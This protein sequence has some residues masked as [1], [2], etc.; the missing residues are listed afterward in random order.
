MKAAGL[1]TR[2]DAAGNTF[3]MLPGEG[4]AVLTGSHIDT[5]PEGG[6]L[7][8]ALGVLAGLEC[9]QTSRRRVCPCG[10]RSRWWR[11][12]TRRGATAA[13]SARG[14]SPAGSTS[15]RSPPCARSTGNRWW[16][17]WRA[18]A[19]TRAGSR[20]PAAIRARC[21]PTWSCTSSRA[22]T[23]SGAHP[24]RPRGGHRGHPPEPPH[25]H[26][27]AGPR[28]HHPDGATQGR[29]P[30]RLRVRAARRA[31]TSSGRAAAGA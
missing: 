25:L 11:G 7:D 24:H 2:V 23:S 12:A 6:P 20:R 17:R 30:G 29:L 31:S 16:R 14:R 4:A 19:T 5:V 15:P 28:R 10:G 22:R 21:T 9:L 18:R 26:R 3:G 27:R 13:S 8:G 1:E